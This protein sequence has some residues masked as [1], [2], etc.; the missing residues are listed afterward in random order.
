MISHL[1]EEVGLR[2]DAMDAF[3][4]VQGPGSFTGLRI[5]ISSINGLAASSG[6]P[7]VGVSSLEALARQCLGFSGNICAMIDARKSEVYFAVYRAEAGDLQ[8][9]TAEQ[10]APPDQ[11]VAATD[12][13]CLFVGSGALLYRHMIEKR[14]EAPAL[15]AAPFQHHIRASTVAYLAWQRME[16]G[17]CAAIQGLVPSYVRQSD[18]QINLQKNDV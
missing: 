9:L 5:G 17:D 10:V 12:T 11:A 8:R 18:A 14:S 13:P 4:V 1:I 3:A 6:K 2:I 7:V 16:Q 15:P